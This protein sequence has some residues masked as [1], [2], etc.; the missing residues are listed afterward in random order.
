MNKNK[1]KAPASECKASM[2]I[3]DIEPYKKIAWRRTIIGWKN[4]PKN[5]APSRTY[6]TYDKNFLIHYLN[7]IVPDMKNT[8]MSSDAKMMDYLCEYA[9]SN[10]P[11]FS[12]RQQFVNVANKMYYVE[13]RRKEEDHFRYI[14]TGCSAVPHDIYM[15]DLRDE[16]MTAIRHIASEFPER[17]SQL[18][19]QCKFEYDSRSSFS[20]RYL[21]LHTLTLYDSYCD[22]WCPSDPD[23]F[24]LVK[25]YRADPKR[26][27]FFLKYAVRPGVEKMIKTVYTC[28]IEFIN[29]VVPHYATMTKLQLNIDEKL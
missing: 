16:A 25:K 14:I 12:L 2:I 11:V 1:K 5:Y 21:I 10:E 29:E 23:K 6:N 28:T 17:E 8:L 7:E 13:L 3:E 26:F 20:L 27:C 19:D 18:I 22:T 15:T 9:N 24:K 4:G